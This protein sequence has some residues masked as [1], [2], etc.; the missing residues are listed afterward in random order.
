MIDLTSAV[1]VQS[2]T[3]YI[4]S[5]A[6]E[7]PDI[8]SSGLNRFTE[9][10]ELTALEYW[11][12]GYSQERLYKFRAL[13]MEGRLSEWCQL[14]ADIF[15]DKSHFHRFQANI[16]HRLKRVS[17]HPAIPGGYLHVALLDQI[18]VEGE[19][20]QA[21]GIFKSEGLNSFLRFHSQEEGYMRWDRHD[22]YPLSKL[23]KGCIILNLEAEDGYTC[24]VVDRKERGTIADFWLK[25][26]L[27]L[28]EVDNEYAQTS[29]MM[30]LAKNFVSSEAKLKHGFSRPEEIDYLNKSQAYFKGNEQFNTNEYVDMVFSDPD[31]AESFTLYKDNQKLQNGE[32]LP[33][34][35]T[36]SNEALKKQGKIFKSV[37]KLDKNFHIYIHGDRSKIQKGRDSEGK[38]FY[39]IFYDTEE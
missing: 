17:Q 18:V 10:Q 21:L 37:L 16:F 11:L 27:E 14:V 32:A 22:G 29:Q 13:D 12:G 24:M 26:F 19:V 23:D 3:H 5:A 33:D 9:E 31:I 1:V 36:I 38:K 2:Y 7:E 35:F 15:S 25:D 4:G 20:I 30:H 28:Q 8:I 6:H 39:K 34:H